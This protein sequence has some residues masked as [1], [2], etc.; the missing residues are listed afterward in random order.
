MS[1]NF[2]W[3]PNKA[4]ANLKKHGVSFDLASYVFV[5]SER[6]EYL[7]DFED[8]G[9]D[10]FRTMGLVSGVLL[11]VVYTM[12]GNS[13]RLISARKAEPHEQITYHENRSPH[14]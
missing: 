13:V 11:V 6:I 3:N 2:E 5:D 7:D 9:E 12:R 8:H 1:L 4:K 10:R 14:D